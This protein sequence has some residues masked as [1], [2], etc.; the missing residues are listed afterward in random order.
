MNDDESSASAALTQS[1]WPIRP[2]SL[3]LSLCFHAGVVL[4]LALIPPGAGSVEKPLDLTVSTVINLQKEP[5][6]YWA[7][8]PPAL[9]AVSPAKQIGD[10]RQFLGAERSVKEKIV[11][12]QP[13]TDPAKQL[14]WQPDKPKPLATET[15]L[16][17]MVAVQGKTSPKPFQPPPDRTPEPQTPKALPEPEAHTTKTELPA[18]VQGLPAIPSVKLKP[19]E[20]VPPTQKPKLTIAGS[21]SDAP[22][23]LADTQ[24]RKLSEIG[25]QVG[26]G[27]LPRRAAPFVPPPARRGTGTQE[28]KDL[29]APPDASSGGTGAVVTAAVIGLDPSAKLASLPDG[30]RGAT[31]SRAPR[32]DA[33]AS[34]AP[35]EGV[36]IPGVAVSG[37]RRAA[38]L[39]PLPPPGGAST[40][41][42]MRTP[43]AASTMSAPLRPSSRT[44]PPAIEARFYNRIV[45]MLVVP[46]PNLPEY[47]ADWTIWFAERVVAAAAPAA[48]RAPLPVRKTIRSDAPAAGDPGTEKWVQVA[49]VI[50]KDGKISAVIPL[51]GRNAA[52]GAKLAVDLINW[53]F[54]PASRSG[55]PIEVDAVIEVP[56]RAR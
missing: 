27:A 14:V 26:T 25:A 20:F 2:A 50:G 43:A 51:P 18:T 31:F 49:G 45:Y 17:N 44:L 12:Q 4:A 13:Q 41:F 22:P 24:V 56:F 40:S 29:P 36:V 11:V 30:S 8:V 42:E 34:G 53:E 54:R 23:D 1:R 15:P 6:I 7:R 21:V 39:L 46:K 10:S 38:V 37:D 3:L 35:G 48:V 9:P 52:I 55:E 32:V 47:A 33:P 5:L 19:K 16:Q 28:G